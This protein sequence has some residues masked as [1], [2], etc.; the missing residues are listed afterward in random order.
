[1]K[2]A[3]AFPRSARHGFTL[4]ELL[5]VIAIIAI[6]AALL[7]PALAKAKIKAQAMVCTSNERQ[8]GL[9]FIMFADEND[10]SM[11]RIAN[12]VWT[13]APFYNLWWGDQLKPYIT[14][15]Y[16]KKGVFSCPAAN[17]LRLN[18]YPFYAGKNITDPNDPSYVNYGYN[19]AI[20]CDT[21]A[22]QLTTKTGWSKITDIRNADL[23]IVADGGQSGH[24]TSA[25]NRVPGFLALDYGYTGN[26]SLWGVNPW[27]NGLCGYLHI[28][29]H[30][31][32]ASY[33]RDWQNDAT[34]DAHAI[35]YFSPSGTA[36]LTPPNPPS[37]P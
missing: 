23:V 7:L 24:F 20:S 33:A 36:D 6:L 18:K 27:H 16:S 21:D 28:D 13:N 22:N 3:T 37:P 26:T 12:G 25:I 4:I 14:S 2:L 34:F 17:A 19:T 10:G 31:D 15:A 32:Q 30:V 9:A 1:M 8:I 11:P 35:K 5:V 29:G